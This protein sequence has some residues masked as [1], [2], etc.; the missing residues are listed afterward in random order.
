ML[1]KIS[2]VSWIK[3]K[4]FESTCDLENMFNFWISYFVSSM[5]K[6]KLIT[7]VLVSGIWEINVLIKF[8]YKFKTSLIFKFFSLYKLSIEVQLLKFCF[9]KDVQ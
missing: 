3:D 8:L 5:F 4:A 1:F 7:S 6:L 2:A 9:G